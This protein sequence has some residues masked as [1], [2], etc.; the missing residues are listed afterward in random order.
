MG[1][2]NCC[3]LK[4]EE[5]NLEIKIG[6]IIQKDSKKEKIERNKVGLEISNQVLNQEK[7]KITFQNSM[8]DINEKSEQIMDIPSRA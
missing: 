3:R 4:L 8:R 6:Q 2:Q 5:K 1:S 7:H